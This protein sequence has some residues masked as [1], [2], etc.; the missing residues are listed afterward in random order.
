MRKMNKSSKAIGFAVYLDALKR[1]NPPKG[2]YDADILLLHNGKVAEALKE[3][4]ILSAG[5]KVV[6]ICAEIPKELT[7]DQVM[8][9]TE[10]GVTEFNGND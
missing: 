8:I 5:G 4:H 2:G 9:L 1:L 10:K 3:A 6:R 7:Y